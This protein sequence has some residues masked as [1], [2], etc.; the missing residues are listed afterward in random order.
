MRLS[1]HIN[2]D[3]VFLHALNMSQQKEPFSSWSKF[4]NSIW[5]ES[6]AIFYFLASSPEYILYCSQNEGILSI[7]K[8]A[9]K[10][11]KKIRRTKQY[12]RLVRE[13]EKYLLLVKKQW[14]KNEKTATHIVENLAG[15]KLP[16]EEIRVFLTHPKLKNGMAV[17][18]KTIVW[19]HPEDYNNYA[20]VYLYHE[21]M[22]ILTHHDPSEIMHAT[23]ELMIDN[24][25]RIR[26][27]G[28]G[29]YFEYPGHAHLQRL[30]QKI[31]PAWKQ[32]LRQKGKNFFGFVKKMKRKRG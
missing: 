5:E 32:Y 28:K 2:P 26:L 25:L 21:I 8:K 24:E 23:I 19:G 29:K 6:P 11:L 4:T 16:T 9:E 27:N 14:L 18:N 30:E 13:T 15:I 17:D 7:A 10:N 22:H 20:T 12:K 3:Y 1:F 31:L